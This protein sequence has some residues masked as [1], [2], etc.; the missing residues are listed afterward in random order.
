MSDVLLVAQLPSVLNMVVS[1]AVESTPTLCDA[2]KGSAAFNKTPTNAPSGGAASPRKDPTPLSPAAPV[3]LAPIDLLRTLGLAMLPPK[4]V[5]QHLA[6][7]HWTLLRYAYLI[8]G[9]QLPGAPLGLGQLAGDYRHHHMT[10]LSEAVG[11]GSTLSYAQEW[12][13]REAPDAVVHPPIDFDY[14]LDAE[15]PA[16]PAAAFV[17]TPKLAPYASRRPDYLIVAERPSG[18]VRLL[19]VEC[20]GN[21]GERRDSVRQ[22]GSAM[23]QLAGISFVGAPHNAVDRHAYAA[24]FSKAGG[25]LEILAIDPPERGERWVRPQR[26]GRETTQL[27]VIGWPTEGLAL[28]SRER[29]GGVALRRASD[30]ALAWAGLSGPVPADVLQRLPRR[31]SDYGDLIGAASSFQLPAGPTVEVFTGALDEVLAAGADFNDD[32]AQTAREAVRQA[33]SRSPQ[34]DDSMLQRERRGRPL[35]SDD[36][37][38]RVASTLTSDGLALRIA[39]TQ[40]IQ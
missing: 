6:S 20:K 11:V 31:P 18:D 15:T 34:V 22:L 12:L 21:S 3:A 35:S 7:W 10:A 37:P 38:E 9:G 27:D 39:V 1:L 4:H 5:E 13:Q 33:F 19:V 29:V 8:D 24:R 14:L 32:R 26:I 23:H 30:R 25:P 40:P 17:V 2:V 16:L 28:P 36:D